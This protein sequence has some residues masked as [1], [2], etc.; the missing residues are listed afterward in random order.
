MVR[1][2]LYMNDKRT[3]VLSVHARTGASGP[4]YGLALTLDIGDGS[5]YA[6]CGYDLEDTN[7]HQMCELSNTHRIW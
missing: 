2:P 3:Y 7:R 5:G 4:P 6:F 1:M